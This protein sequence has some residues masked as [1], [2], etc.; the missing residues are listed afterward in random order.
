SRH[1]ST[2]LNV[3]R[4]R[5]TRTE[6]KAKGRFFAEGSSLCYTHPM[7]KTRGISLGVGVAIGVAI[8]AAMDNI[9]AGIGIGIAL[10]LAMGWL[11]G[12]KVTPD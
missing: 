8:G 4:H 1:A 2:A 3:S 6:G 9:G 10:A 7:T 11:G 5:S 12:R